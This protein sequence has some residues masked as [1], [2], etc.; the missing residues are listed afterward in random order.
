MA[1]DGLLAQVLA[2]TRYCST[3]DG[4]KRFAGKIWKAKGKSSN[5]SPDREVYIDLSPNRQPPLMKSLS[6]RELGRSSGG[7]DSKLS[8][9][10]KT[11]PAVLRQTQRGRVST[12][13]RVGQRHERSD[14]DIST[15]LERKILGIG[16]N[17]VMGGRYGAQESGVSSGNKGCRSVPDLYQ[18]H[19]MI[20]AGLIYAQ[21]H[22][23]QWSE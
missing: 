8:L 1:D 5:S 6:Q 10:L 18:F 20:Q 23:G 11:P 4:C 15:K 2:G 17:R 22:V 16:K 7:E 3:D 13:N 12:E 9:R 14:R 21:S 19:Q